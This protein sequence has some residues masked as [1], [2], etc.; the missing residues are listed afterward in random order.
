PYAVPA[1]DAVLR[2]PPGLLSP[3]PLPYTTLFRSFSVFAPSG[4]ALAFVGAI[5][6][7]TMLIAALL[8]MVQDDIKRVLAYSTVS[9]HGDRANRD[10]KST[11]LNSS[12]QIISYADFCLQ[13]NVEFWAD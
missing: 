11:R 5:G 10:R 9:Q 8:A 1:V 3:S 13:K 4:H 12:H 6:S 7:I 2:P